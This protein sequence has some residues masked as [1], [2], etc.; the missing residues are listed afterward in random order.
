MRLPYGA[1]GHIVDNY[2]VLNYKVHELIN[3]KAIAFMPNGSNVKNNPML[4]HM[5]PPISTVEESDSQ[6]LVTGV[7]EIQTLML[8]IKEQLL[9]FGSIPVNHVYCEGCTSNPETCERLKSCAQQ[10]IDQGTVQVGSLTKG[11][12]E[13]ATLEIPYPA[14]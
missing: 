14:T 3:Y 10:L 1:P 6:E 5:G 13:V 2:K 11:E 12:E 8:V 9:K 4:T 7:E